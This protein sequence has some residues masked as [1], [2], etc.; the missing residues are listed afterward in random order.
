MFK[1]GN[2]YK[3][4]PNQRDFEWEKPLLEEFW[5]DLI[6]S[7]D[8]KDKSY[9]FG[10]TIFEYGDNNEVVIYDGQQRLAVVTTLWAVVR[11]LLHVNFKETDIADTIQKNYI[12]ERTE[13]KE[14]IVKLT[15]N[16]RNKDF[17]Y[18][19]IQLPPDSKKTFEEY[20]K[21][22]GKLNETNKKIKNCYLFFKEA[23]NKAFED[24]KLGMDKE[25]IEFMTDISQHLRDHF[26]LVIIGITDEEEAYMVF[27]TVNQKRAELSVADLFKNYLIRKT[28]KAGDRKK[29]IELWK[30]IA[31][32]L[33][34]KIKAFLKHYWHSKREVITERRLFK[35][36]KKY[37]EK[38]KYNPLELVNELKGEAKI[39]SALGNPDDDY[40]DKK[41]IKELVREFNILNV[42]Q[43]LPVLVVGRKKFSNGTFKKLLTLMINFSFRYNIICNLPPNVLERKYSDIA[44]NIRDGKIKDI[45]S[46]INE[47]KKIEKYPNDKLFAEIFI[48]KI[49]KR[50]KNKLARYILEKIEVNKQSKMP[51]TKRPEPLKFED[52]TLEHIL[53][54]SPDDEWKTYFKTKG[55]SDEDVEKLIYRVGNLTLLDNPKNSFVKNEF[56][57]KKCQKAYNS[58]LLKINESLHNLKEW[59]EKDIEKREAYFLKEAREV[60]NIDDL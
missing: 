3:V 16:L 45:K 37:I 31:D 12:S 20:E 10:S 48:G 51:I 8:A 34:N 57:T 14:N 13:K 6:N 30:D 9:F 22:H 44:I 46:I 4:P 60:W 53:P 15:L 29:V 28:K 42:K 35:E 47:I 55:I 5:N 49:L 2:F 52:F 41:D 19:C 32:A 50:G 59:N 7:Y 36:L 1:G 33:D 25:K 21:I 23:I 58:S 11:D 18:D 40:W 27:E 54:Q 56:I 38:E 43:P 24:R 39:Y 26:S 17:F